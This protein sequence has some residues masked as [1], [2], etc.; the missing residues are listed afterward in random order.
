MS[1]VTTYCVV[2]GHLEAGERA[3]YVLS[4]SI[5]KAAPLAAPYGGICLELAGE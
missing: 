2:G 1:H 4:A 3:L 5:L